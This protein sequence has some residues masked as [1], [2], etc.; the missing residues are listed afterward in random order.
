[1]G[2]RGQSTRVTIVQ[3]TLNHHVFSSCICFLATYTR[4]TT[5]QDAGQDYAAWLSAWQPTRLEGARGQGLGPEGDPPSSSMAWTLRSAR[6]AQEE[7]PEGAQEHGTF[8]LAIDLVAIPTA[9]AL[10][11]CSSRMEVFQTRA[12]G[13]SVGVI[14][15]CG[16]Q[17]AQQS[18]QV[19][20]LSSAL[21]L[22]RPA[23]RGS[24][25]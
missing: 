19:L 25:C 18:R 11:A 12:S 15:P 6:G 20:T 23:R 16:E 21:C 7:G 22:P 10:A 3:Q 8:W 13:S 24:P 4:S 9:D 5:R 2:P 17:M 14:D 1:M